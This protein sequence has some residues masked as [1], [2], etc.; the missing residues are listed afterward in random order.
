MSDLNEARAWYGGGWQVARGGD[1]CTWL[2]HEALNLLKLWW[3]M[4]WETPMCCY[5]MCPRVGTRMVNSWVVPCWCYL[6]M[7]IL[8]STAQCRVFGPGD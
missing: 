1:E 4:V 7:S 8:M 6:V 5:A 2:C 3:G